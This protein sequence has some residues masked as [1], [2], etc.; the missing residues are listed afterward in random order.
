M[1]DKN[2]LLK[3]I[4]QKRPKLLKGDNLEKFKAADLPGKV[5]L[6]HAGDEEFY[7]KECNLSIGPSET[8]ADL[9]AE[10]VGVEATG[11]KSKLLFF[12]P[13]KIGRAHV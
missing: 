9:A 3:W 2:E 11:V 13:C 12:M 10:I 5:F 8:L 4:Q 7:K 1:W 6:K